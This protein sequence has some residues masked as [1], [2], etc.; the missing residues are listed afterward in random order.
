MNWCELQSCIF[1]SVQVDEMMGKI[2]ELESGVNRHQ[3]EASELKV[4]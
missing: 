1:F 3:Y 4:Q 2:S